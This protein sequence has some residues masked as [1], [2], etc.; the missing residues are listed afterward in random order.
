MKTHKEKIILA[1]RILMSV[2]F[3]FSAYSK[4]HSSESIGLVEHDINRLGILSLDNAQFLSRIVIAIEILIGIAF[5]EGSFLKKLLIPG[6]VLMLILFCIHLS[7]TGAKYGFN[8]G[9]CGCF[10]DL[11]PMSPL[12][13][14]LKNLIT[15]GFLIYMWFGIKVD[16]RKKIATISTIAGLC[17]VFMFLFFPMKDYNRVLID[18]PVVELD[19]TSLK[20]ETKFGRFNSA[21][22]EETQL[23]CLYLLNNNNCKTDFKKLLSAKE[24]LDRTSI[25]VIGYGN[26]DDA[27]SFVD[28]KT[29]QNHITTIEYDDFKKLLDGNGFP[30]YFLVK[31]GE[32]I[33]NWTKDEFSF[34]SLQSKLDELN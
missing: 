21:L 24:L 6:T 4:L 34:E 5:L 30:R 12:E 26:K 13:A 22:D 32:E 11:L 18:E 10:G 33:Q 28:K 29:N 17:L 31:N 23:I 20:S 14:I 15:I 19:E 7:I 2:L 27:E 1:L 16:N 9:N 3:L 25:H 8:N